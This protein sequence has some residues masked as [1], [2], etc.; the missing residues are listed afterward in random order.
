MKGYKELLSAVIKLAVEDGDEEYINS[1][2][3]EDHCF[4][5][6]IQDD[7]GLEAVRSRCLKEIRGKK[8]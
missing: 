6:G 7:I 3:F 2:T 4:Y 1:S 8:S 5:L